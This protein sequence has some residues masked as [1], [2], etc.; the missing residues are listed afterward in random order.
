VTI[1]SDLLEL[2]NTS[3][4]S[5]VRR[6]S[7]AYP[8]L[9]ALHLC[10]IAISAG[11][12]LVTDLRL[13]GVSFGNYPADELVR[14]LRVPKRFGLALVLA[15]GLL[16]AMSNAARYYLNP[17]FRVKMA[18]LAALV[19]HAICTRRLYAN[20]RISGQGKA[21]PRALRWAAL[22]SLMLWTGV[23]IAGRG[24]GYVT[25][26]VPAPSTKWPGANPFNV[27]QPAFL[28]IKFS[29]LCGGET[30]ATEIGWRSL[31]GALPP[32]TY[33]FT[34]GVGF[35]GGSPG[36]AGRLGKG[37]RRSRMYRLS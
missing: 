6:S 37:H 34:F 7:Y 13:M 18:L 27:V 32:P 35:F 12:V 2:Q 28:H 3:F 8:I 25:V 4:L 36:F 20:A 24:I 11:M 29:H 26:P 33:R 31:G 10:G 5:A 1:V 9:L 19:A 21:S 30:S 14:Q 15:C 23:V 16:L 22:V 17:V